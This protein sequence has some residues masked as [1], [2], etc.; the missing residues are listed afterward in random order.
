[1]RS[2]EINIS[3]SRLD[4]LLRAVT[5][6]N[7]LSDIKPSSDPYSK[8]VPCRSE[9]AIRSFNLPFGWSTNEQATGA[10]VVAERTYSALNSQYSF[11]AR[12]TWCSKHAVRI[13][14]TWQVNV[15]GLVTVYNGDRQ[16]FM[17]LPCILIN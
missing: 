13:D 5:R 15:I 11:T 7:T 8:I 12:G 2:H 6:L 4:Q 3:Q 1:M 10:R 16:P 14:T 17:F 9:A